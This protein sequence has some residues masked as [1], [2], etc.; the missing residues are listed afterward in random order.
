MNLNLGF[1]SKAT[2]LLLSGKDSEGLRK[3]T[4]VVFSSND[5]LW[6]A[7]VRGSGEVII[8]AGTFATPQILE[9]SGAL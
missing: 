5:L 2:Q 7:K 1:W 9:M 8:A 6:K 4:G 3:V